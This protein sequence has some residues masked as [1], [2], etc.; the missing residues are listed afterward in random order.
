VKCIRKFLFYLSLDEKILSLIELRHSTSGGA[1][2]EWRTPLVE[3]R[4][5]FAKWVSRW[6]ACNICMRHFTHDGAC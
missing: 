3:R 2:R 4:T 1:L 5:H 6:A